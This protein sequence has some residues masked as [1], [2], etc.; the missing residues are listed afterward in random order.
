MNG[1]FQTPSPLKLLKIMVDAMAVAEG[2][3]GMIEIT[4]LDHFL[5]VALDCGLICG[6]RM[7]PEMDPEFSTDVKTW[8]ILI[9]AA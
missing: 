6:E 5:K 7:V 1:A 2:F 9:H 8:M 4:A 3:L